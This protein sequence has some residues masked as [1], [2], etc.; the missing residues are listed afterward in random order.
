MCSELREE[1]FSA[2]KRFWCADG[3]AAS[4]A[5]EEWLL[6]KRAIDDANALVRVVDL[7]SWCQ[8]DP[9]TVRD[10]LAERF[11]DLTGGGMSLPR[12]FGIDGIEI[13]QDTYQ[14]G[15]SSIRWRT[16]PSCERLRGQ[17]LLARLGTECLGHTGFQ[18][19]LLRLNWSIRFAGVACCDEGVVARVVF[20]TA[21][22][23]WRKLA[24]QALA[25]VVGHL[26]P[27]IAWWSAPAELLADLFR[28][29]QIGVGT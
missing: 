9:Q 28:S 3:K 17:V 2:G 23:R 24:E 15:D 12:A 4:D 21:D 25:A 6:S 18:G 19:Y 16:S 11:I 29:A 5:T 20:P 14:A 13:G 27:Q 1:S 26:Q 8:S 10:L 22:E 7:P